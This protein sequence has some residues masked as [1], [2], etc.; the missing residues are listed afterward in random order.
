[1]LCG[2]KRSRRDRDSGVHGAAKRAREMQNR[3]HA[4]ADGR[5]EIE[6]KLAVVR[7]AAAF[8]FP[9]GD[10]NSLYADVEQGRGTPEDL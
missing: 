2:M 5:L 10:I 7:T 3:V 8:A 4:T 6:R 1:M 9:T